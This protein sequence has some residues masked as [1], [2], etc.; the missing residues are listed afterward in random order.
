MGSFLYPG[1]PKVEPI[2]DPPKRSRIVMITPDTA[3][4]NRYRWFGCVSDYTL[5]LVVSTSFGSMRSLTM[6]LG[7]SDLVHKPDLKMGA[8]LARVRFRLY[9]FAC[10]F[11]RFLAHAVNAY[12]AGDPRYGPPN[13]PHHECGD[14][15]SDSIIWPISNQRRA[16]SPS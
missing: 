11:H 8:G 9:T 15:Q 1:A 2:W 7:P 16:E 6:D 3:A 5:L 12:D 14:S 13:R 10:G 4:S